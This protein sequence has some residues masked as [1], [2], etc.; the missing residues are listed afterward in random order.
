MGR[1]HAADAPPG[2][3]SVTEKIVWSVGAPLFFGGVMTAVSFAY[4]YLLQKRS[5]HLS[6]IFFIIL[7]VLAALCLIRLLTPHAFG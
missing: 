5:I 7:N 6:N 1:F 3:I 2:D 4:H